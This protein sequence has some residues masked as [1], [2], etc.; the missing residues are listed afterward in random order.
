MAGRRTTLVLGAIIAAAL[1][2]AS[3]GIPRCTGVGVGGA[4]RGDGEPDERPDERSDVPASTEAKVVVQAERCVL[5]GQSA[6][7]CPEV[8]RL[9][10]ERAPEVVVLD[11]AAG[12]HGIVEAFRGC[13]VEG[14]V[15][16]RMLG[17]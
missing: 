16:V 17:S 3:L 1:A 13:L 11:G 9:L 2:L 10:L 5:D 14:G 4:P 12:A 6:A 15:S 7:P 8:C